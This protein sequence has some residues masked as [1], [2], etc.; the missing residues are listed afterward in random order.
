M[1]K[2][3]KGVAL[4]AAIAEWVGQVRLPKNVRQAV[5]IDPQSFLK[6]GRRPLGG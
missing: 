4:Q 5:D 6:R 2:A 3:E 1:L